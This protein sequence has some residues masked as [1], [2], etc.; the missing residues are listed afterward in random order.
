MWGWKWAL[1]A[2]GHKRSCRVDGNVLK[3]KCADVYK[4]ANFLKNTAC[5]KW[6]IFMILTYK[7]VLPKN[8]S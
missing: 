2:N 1:I 8:E 7:I 4:T 5:L 3:L 6:M